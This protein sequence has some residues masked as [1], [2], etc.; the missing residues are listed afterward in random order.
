MDFLIASDTHGAYDLLRAVWRKQVHKPDGL[1][2]LGDGLKDLWDF[3]SFAPGVP[4]LAVRGNCDFTKA[5]PDGTV[6]EVSMVRTFEDVK[7]FMT[8]GHAYGVKGGDTHLLQAG[9]SNG[10]SVILYG[11]THRQEARFVTDFGR[12]V[13]ICNPGSLRDKGQFATISLCG[14]QAVIGL[15]ELPR[16]ALL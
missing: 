12:P 16:S 13:Q 15:G 7:V 10:A 8:H 6:A 11:H 5:L 9:I 2:F 4:I 3:S 1:I 14:G